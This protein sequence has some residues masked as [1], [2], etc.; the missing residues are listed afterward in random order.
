MYQPKIKLAFQKKTAPHISELEFS[1][2]F[3]VPDRFSSPV[4]LEHF[5]WDLDSFGEPMAT[6]KQ[7]SINNGS[8]LEKFM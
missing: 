1:H 8:A 4:G 2:D 3:S 6:L 7:N 5:C